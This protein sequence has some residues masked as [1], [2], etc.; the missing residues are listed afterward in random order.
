M[1]NFNIETLEPYRIGL[2]NF[3]LNC[4]DSSIYYYENSF[5]PELKNTCGYTQGDKL[6]RLKEERKKLLQDL[7]SDTKL[8][9]LDFSKSEIL[10]FLRLEAIQQREKADDFKHNPLIKIPS[11]KK[12]VKNAQLLI[13]IEPKLE[14]YSLHWLTSRNPIKIN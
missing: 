2:I 1:K 11:L 3:R 6:R 13:Q 9:Y 14:I 10:N 7:R 4:L 8:K 12:A 5:L